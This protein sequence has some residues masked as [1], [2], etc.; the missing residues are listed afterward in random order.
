MRDIIAESRRLTG[1]PEI[2]PRIVSRAI[3]PLRGNVIPPNATR[4]PCSQS[5]VWTVRPVNHSTSRPN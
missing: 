2:E 3:S 1:K 5:A 4:A